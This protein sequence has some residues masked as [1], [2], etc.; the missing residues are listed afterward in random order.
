MSPLWHGTAIQ[1]RP[2]GYGLLTFAI[3]T[4]VFNTVMRL[5]T[6]ISNLSYPVYT[7]SSKH[8]FTYLVYRVYRCMIAKKPFIC[9]VANSKNTLHKI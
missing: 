8:I 4:C 9:F 3:F 2:F 7:L 6:S 1:T 5:N